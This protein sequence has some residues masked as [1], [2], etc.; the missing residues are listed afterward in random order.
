M[1][2]RASGCHLRKKTHRDSVR[3]Q[4]LGSFPTF[5]IKLAI[6]LETQCTLSSYL[7]ERHLE[8]ELPYLPGLEEEL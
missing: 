3:I 7:R 4:K 1:N 6:N 2:I 8:E 5:G